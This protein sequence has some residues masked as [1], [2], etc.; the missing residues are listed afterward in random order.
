MIIAASVYY[1]VTGAFHFV[2]VSEAFDVI[3]ATVDVD[4]EAILEYSKMDMATY[5]NA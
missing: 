2:V 1:D 5:T 4:G 3:A